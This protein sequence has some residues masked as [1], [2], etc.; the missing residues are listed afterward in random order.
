MVQNTRGSGTY[1][2][3]EVPYITGNGE[4]NGVSV[5]L[6]YS[7]PEEHRVVFMKDI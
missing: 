1:L 3:V 7:G 2:Q 4:I 5:V 6:D